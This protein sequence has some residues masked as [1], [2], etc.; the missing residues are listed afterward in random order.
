MRT[1]KQRDTEWADDQFAKITPTQA[2]VREFDNSEDG[3]N[4]REI[5]GMTM[6][7]NLGG[8]TLPPG[9]REETR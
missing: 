4:Y 5:T 3:K 8:N 1:N 2:A 9:P 6:W 7:E